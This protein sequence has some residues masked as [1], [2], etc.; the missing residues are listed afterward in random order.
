METEDKTVVLFDGVC[1]LC[2]SVVIFLIKRDRKKVLFFTALQSEEGQK[3]LKSNHLKV[4]NFDSFVLYHKGKVYQKSSAGIRVL[5]KLGGL[6]L[7][8]SIFLIVPTPIRNWVYSLIANNRYKWWG[9]KD[10]CMIPTPE[11]K[12]RFL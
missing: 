10:A 7:L 4:D 5:A 9:Q 12:S 6:W 8:M 2:N 3:I 1:N 11:L